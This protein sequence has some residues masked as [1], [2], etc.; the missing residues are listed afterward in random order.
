MERENEAHTSTLKDLS[1]EVSMASKSAHS[2]GNKTDELKKV[3]EGL[4]KRLEKLE[5]K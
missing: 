1:K 2:T 3:V 5:K 4:K